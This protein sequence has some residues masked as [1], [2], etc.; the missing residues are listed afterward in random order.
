LG[1]TVRQL[2]AEIDSAELGEWAAYYK[3]EPFGE[4]VADQRHGIAVST[5]ANVNRDSK[6]RPEPYTPTDFIYWRPQPQASNDGELLPD[7]EAQSRLLIAKF[8]QLRG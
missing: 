3:L 8:A 5:L 7:A 2:L 6:R 4:L 1:K